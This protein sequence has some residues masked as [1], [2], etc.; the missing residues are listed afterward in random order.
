MKT[1]NIALFDVLFNF[2]N[3][4]EQLL[5]YYKIYFML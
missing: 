3:F 5:I 1:I 4:L 2:K